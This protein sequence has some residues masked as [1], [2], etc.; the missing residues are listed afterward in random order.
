MATLSNPADIAEL[1]VA[2]REWLVQDL[3]LMA[4]TTN[5]RRLA[6]PRGRSIVLGLAV[7]T[8]TRAWEIPCMR[9][10][11]MTSAA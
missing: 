11:P 9:S 1:V 2:Q 4:G 6:D 7:L 10:R 3:G 8:G 5:L